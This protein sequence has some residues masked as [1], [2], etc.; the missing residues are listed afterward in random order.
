MKR[1]E[2]LILLLLLVLLVLLVLVVSIVTLKLGDKRV[3]QA[4]EQYN[5]CK[6]VLDHDCLEYGNCKCKE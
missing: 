1:Y 5:K 6:I 3:Q 2:V 4:L